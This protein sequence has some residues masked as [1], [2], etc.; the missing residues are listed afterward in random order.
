[1]KIKVAIAD[2]HMIMI[3]GIEKILHQH[4]V[5]ELCGTYL[6][7]AALLNGLKEHQPDVLLLDIQMPDMPGDELARII[8]HQYP[9]TAILALTNMDMAFHVRTMLHNGARGYLLKSVDDHTLVQ[10]ITALSQGKT[11]IDKTIKE[12][13]KGEEA[14]AF[15]LN[16]GT[17]SKR[18]KEI[19]E[20]IAREMTTPQIASSL[21]IS[22]STVES[23]RN[24]M[25][26]KMGVKN[27]A[28]LVMKAVQLGL[29]K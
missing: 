15:S 13:M 20:L 1:M 27:A 25:F 16:M 21:F 8:S 11:F 19:L 2:D 6:N 9:D 17:L 29:I 23:H 14:E 3:K 5:V 26:Y 28:G 24:N 12:K 4:V 7:G 22:E 10:A 18:E